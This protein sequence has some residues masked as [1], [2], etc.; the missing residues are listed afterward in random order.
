M[1]ALQSEPD[2]DD[3]AVFGGGLHV[4]VQNPERATLRIREVLAANGIEIRRLE[5]ITPSMEDVF[6][7]LIEQQAREKE[8]REKAV[9]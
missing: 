1:Q 8:A 3:V 6:V 2:V 9:K 7:A 5:R 4:T